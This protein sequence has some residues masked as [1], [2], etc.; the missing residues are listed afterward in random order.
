MYH[1]IYKNWIKPSCYE[2][3]E[4]FNKCITLL[5]AISFQIWRSVN[6]FSGDNIHVFKIRI[7]NLCFKLVLNL[8]PILSWSKQILVY[9]VDNKNDSLFWLRFLGMSTIFNVFLAK[10]R[11]NVFF[12][13]I[14]IE[15]DISWGNLQLESTMFLILL[16]RIYFGNSF[17]FERIKQIKS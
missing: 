10:K 9:I 1:F 7:R 2:V 15:V 14:P 5:I 16:R 13:D 4:D 6:N 17:T 12:R 8:A 11:L 3:I